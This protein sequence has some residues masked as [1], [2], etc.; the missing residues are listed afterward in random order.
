MQSPSKGLAI[1]CSFPRS[2]LS[3]LVT[4]DMIYIDCCPTPDTGP[5][6]GQYCG[7][8]IYSNW[9]RKVPSPHKIT[10]NHQNTE[11]PEMWC[12]CICSQYHIT[13]TKF[14]QNRY[15]MHAY[16]TYKQTEILR[17]ATSN[18]HLKY[19]VQ[20][21]EIH[22][23]Q[24]NRHQSDEDSP[25]DTARRLRLRLVWWWKCFKAPEVGWNWLNQKKLGVTKSLNNNCCYQ[26]EFLRNFTR[27]MVNTDRIINSLITTNG[28]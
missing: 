7:M 5:M 18:I 22:F 9:Q 8:W 13:L 6:P 17:W 4:D 27:M 12:I 24:T 15:A 10:A 2:L 23:F 19:D 11:T 26:Q 16:C 25:P 1:V 3:L 20:C 28:R 14:P 21:S